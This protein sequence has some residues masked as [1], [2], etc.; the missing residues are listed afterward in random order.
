MTQFN[1]I[2]FCFIAVFTVLNWMDNYKLGELLG[3][4]YVLK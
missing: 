2:H 4:G 3:V 1:L